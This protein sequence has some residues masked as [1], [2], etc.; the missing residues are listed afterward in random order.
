MHGGAYLSLS[1]SLLRVVGWCTFTFRYQAALRV[2]EA[3]VL[4]VSLAQSFAA[5]GRLQ[6][7]LHEPVIGVETLT[8]A[9]R[10]FWACLGPRHPES[11]A[12]LTVLAAAFAATKRPLMAVG[13][14]AQLAALKLSVQSTGAAAQRS[15]LVSG[16]SAVAAARARAAIPTSTA[17]SLSKSMET[18]GGGGGG[19]GTAATATSLWWDE[20]KAVEAKTAKALAAAQRPWCPQSL[21]PAAAAACVDPA[22]ATAA[23]EMER[24]RS[25]ILAQ[26]ASA[27]CGRVVSGAASAV[28]Q[29]RSALVAALEAC[30]PEL[31]FFSGPSV[32]SDGVLEDKASEAYNDV[33]ASVTWAIKLADPASESLPLGALVRREVLGLSH[34]ASVSAVAFDGHRS[35]VG[36]AVG[37]AG[38]AGGATGGATGPQDRNGVSD[39][40]E[41]AADSPLTPALARAAGRLDGL[42]SLLVLSSLGRLGC[43]VADAGFVPGG[44]NASGPFGLGPTQGA[45]AAVLLARCAQAPASRD[46]RQDHVGRASE[47]G[48]VLGRGAAVTLPTLLRHATTAKRER[49]EAQAT[50]AVVAA[51]LALR[52][53]T[54]NAGGKG[55]VGGAAALWSGSGLELLSCLEASCDFRGLCRGE[56]GAGGLLPLA[57]ECDRQRAFALR[58]RENAPSGTAA[59]AAARRQR[60]S[61]SDGGAGS[62]FPSTAEDMGT[63]GRFGAR[64]GLLHD[65]LVGFGPD[66]AAA[67]ASAGGRAGEE[68]RRGAP[69]V[70]LLRIA[71]VGLRTLL[72]DLASDGGVDGGSFDTGPTVTAAGEGSGGGGDGG[73]D[74]GESLGLRVKR[75][76]TKLCARVAGRSGYSDRSREKKAL[77]RLQCMLEAD[78]SVLRRPSFEQSNG[79]AVPRRPTRKFQLE[80]ASKKSTGSTGSKGG[81][82]AAASGRRGARQSRNLEDGG[83]I[84]GNAYEDEDYDDDTDS[85][86][87]NRTADATAGTSGSLGNRGRLDAM[88]RLMVRSRYDLA[89]ALDGLDEGDRR[90]LVHELS[91]SGCFLGHNCAFGGAEARAAKARAIQHEN[92]STASAPAKKEPKVRMMGKKASDSWKSFH[93]E[94]NEGGGG[95]GGD[96]GGEENDGGGGDDDRISKSQGVDDDE[97]YASE[98][99]SG[100]TNGYTSGDTSGADSDASNK[101]KTEG[102]RRE[103]GSAHYYGRHGSGGG[104]GGDNDDELGVGDG[105]SRVEDREVPIT[106]RGA[107]NLLRSVYW[108]VLT[109]RRMAF[110]AQKKAGDHER[111]HGT[112]I[113][114][115]HLNGKTRWRDSFDTPAPVLGRDEAN[116]P[117]VRALGAALVMLAG[118][119]RGARLALAQHQ[120]NALAAAARGRHGHCHGGGANAAGCTGAASSPGG[121]GGGGGGQWAP[122]FGTHHADHNAQTDAAAFSA[123]RAAAA[124]EEAAEEAASVFSPFPV[125]CCA[126]SAAGTSHT[127]RAMARAMVGYSHEAVAALDRAVEMAAAAADRATPAGGGG[128]G[129]GPASPAHGGGSTG[130]GRALPKREPRGGRGSAPSLGSS[131]GSRCG[132][133][134]DPPSRSGSG[135]RTAKRSAAKKSPE[136]KEGRSVSGGG[137]GGGSG[138]RGLSDKQLSAALAEAAGDAAQRSERCLDELSRGLRSCRL[139]VPSAERSGSYAVCVAFDKAVLGRHYKALLPRPPESVKLVDRVRTALNLPPLLKKLSAGAVAESNDRGGDDDDIPEAQA[140]VGAAATQA[141]TLAAHVAPPPTPCIII[142]SPGRGQGSEM[143]MV[144]AKAMVD[145]G[146]L[147]LKAVIANL[148][149]CRERARLVRGSLDVLNLRHVPTGVG[150]DRNAEAAVQYAAALERR[151]AAEEEARAALEAAA[152][153]VEAAVSGEDV[154][155]AAAH[156]HHNHRGRGGLFSSVSSAA[157]PPPLPPLPP[158]PPKVKSAEFNIQVKAQGYDYLRREADRSDGRA[159]LLETFEAAAPASLAVLCITALTDLADLVKHHRALFAAKAKRVVMMGGVDEDSL[160]PRNAMSHVP[161]ASTEKRRRFSFA[162][163]RDQEGDEK[164]A[165]HLRPDQSAQN[166]Q[167]DWEASTFVFTACQELGVQLVVLTRSAAYACPVP[168]FIYDELAVIGHPIALRLRSTQ[169]QSITGLWRRASLP[170]GHPNRLGLP[171]RCDRSWFAKSFCGGADLSEIPADV[172]SIWSQI[173]AFNMYD[174]LAL[175]LVDPRTSKA[176]FEPEAKVVDGV[177]HL[178]V[179]VEK[180]GPRKSTG[181]SDVQAL[182]DFLMDAARLSLE[183]S[184]TTALKYRSQ[185]FHVAA[186]EATYW[187]RR[188]RNR[189]AED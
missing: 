149:P 65:A 106:L 153:T 143:V 80:R 173:T 161:L 171:D 138:G 164:G 187:D 63:G 66:L 23:I 168:A 177:E 87:D 155:A 186:G 116:D 154:G 48:T 170:A 93:Y 67:L 64:V 174:P 78:V 22:A 181:V 120:R 9:G 134:S 49:A 147:E 117:G 189:D 32:G 59:A 52:A 62:V 97:D 110:D 99:G 184:M 176:F 86:G 90:L 4:D 115:A 16:P 144:L 141:S 47:A 10:Q 68:G 151:A 37:T 25:S 105:V 124:A 75:C 15:A 127:E 73:D 77:T 119:F 50:M 137:C 162:N 108:E 156:H 185:S 30:Y 28:K 57:R 126:A 96:G 163:D 167:Y 82:A 51:S 5:L 188:R 98:A 45:A 72:R 121:G 38:G 135:E 180:E 7:D 165:D 83:G 102:K 179:G 56:V 111:A 6:C 103:K 33:L 36:A 158:K 46:V 118:L 88:E 150:I 11:E 12:C 148:A 100:H 76:H 95:D 129:L 44:G 34:D 169:E 60:A 70:S 178:V 157:E 39:L 125:N 139:E 123:A 20:N 17:A 140:C 166:N 74:N 43:L 92:S 89:M 61:A 130:K 172:E 14:R 113:R 24:V 182:R 31:G 84:G 53:T 159:L 21:S 133:G 85:V 183:S 81:D 19:G 122:Y 94:V 18:K 145:L 8:C 104:S 71:H 79:H 152:V 41:G 109:A 26:R 29:P 2:R 107:S 112:A 146:L 1:L 40:G 132:S 13:F 131:A 3:L 160:S 69:L 114:A 175:L 101:K 27:F 128:D 54:G 55:G 91:V 58:W 42:L 136:P 142:T 35:G